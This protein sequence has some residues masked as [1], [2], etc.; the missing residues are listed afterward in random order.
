V[1]LVIWYKVEISQA[2]PSGGLNGVL[3]AAA[4]VGGLGLPIAVSN[5]LFAGSAVLDADICVTMTEGASAD[6]FEITLINLPTRTTDL[7]RAVRAREALAVSVHLGYFDEPAMRNTDLGR[8]LVGRIT[9]V[10]GRVGDDG[11]A[12]TTL[13]GQEEAGY[14]LRNK[15]ASLSNAGPVPRFSIA[16]ALLEGTGVGLA[17]GSTLP[18]ELSDFTIQSKSTLDAL[19]DLAAQ[20]G[21][22][23]VVRD[24]QV[25][26]GAAVGRPTDTTPVDFDPDTNIVSLEPTSGED[27]D[28][29][30][31]PP[32]RDAVEVTVLGHPGLR[33]G[34]VGKITGLSDV[35]SEPMRVSQVVHKFSTSGGYT[36]TVRLIVASPGQRAQIT[37]GVQGVVNRVRD[38]IGRV[39]D[40]HPFIDIGEV[41]S[42]ASGADGKHLATMHYGQSP[43]GSVV[44]PSVASPVDNTVDLHDKPI[45]SAFA[46]DRAGLVVPVYP[47]MRALLAH[48]RGLVNDALV[49]GFVWPEATPARRPA[50]EP[51]DYW[52]ALPTGLDSDG[53]PT[54]P[55]VNDLT[56]ATGHRVIQASGLHIMV[57]TDALPDVG[58]RPD[59]PEDNTITIEH[60]AGTTITV[61]A[62]G[63]VTITTDSKAITLTNGSVSLALDGSAVAVS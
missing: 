33:V 19:A 47:K 58:T 24:K 29:L 18:G 7:I 57:G 54:G 40:D 3:A 38:V 22:A 9:R 45:A 15:G 63:A 5:D 31:N 6:T 60:A 50:N 46:F 26:L 43:S 59:P 4:A 16:Q 20:A 14:R 55:G 32:V 11:L 37:T 2:A 1:S 30:P 28:D 41:T 12:R 23:F 10:T 13:Y 48:N 17:Q 25:F 34:Q 51:G 42:Y 36:T 49:A 39:Q 53:L 62:D 56:D 52:L 8:V 44:A 27:S 35:P 61:G 21:V